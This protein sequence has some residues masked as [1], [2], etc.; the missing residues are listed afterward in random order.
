MKPL[1]WLWLALLSTLIFAGCSTSSA[2]NNKTASASKYAGKKFIPAK[3]GGGYYLDDGPGDLI[4]AN[5]DSIPDAIPVDEPNHRWANRPYAALGVNYTPDTSNRPYQASG[6]ASWYGKKF[7]GK[8]T[9][10]GEAYDMFAMTGAHPTLPIP[11]YVR[12]TNKRNGKT[13]VVRINDRG[14]FH[15]GRLIDLSYAAAYKLGY[16]DTGSASVSVERVWPDDRV[17]STT[18]LAANELPKPADARPFASALMPVS[19]PATIANDTVATTTRKS[20]DSAGI[21]LQLGAFGSQANAEAQRTR[22]QAMINDENQEGDL[23]IV[24]RDGLYRVRLGPFVSPARAREVAQALKV[25]T[26]VMR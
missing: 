25:Q 22:L 6:T 24:D 20:M 17:N 9:S 26:V 12:V 15:K 8:R 19:R 13:V 16:V 23:E 5:L 11:S 3:K 2:P 21:W 10:S 1:R 7:Q 14:P 18:R 4:P